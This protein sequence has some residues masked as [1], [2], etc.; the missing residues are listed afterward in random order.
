VLITGLFITK[1]FAFNISWRL[2][3]DL[4]KMYY[5][6]ELEKF[7][8]NKIVICKNNKFFQE[9]K[10]TRVNLELIDKLTLGLRMRKIKCFKI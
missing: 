9:K 8:K 1:V 2:V 7:L 4:I 6:S 10:S 3:H 5:F